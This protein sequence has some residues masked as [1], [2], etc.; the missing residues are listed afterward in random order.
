MV[1]SYCRLK[2]SLTL[3]V[4]LQMGMIYVVKVSLSMFP[5]VFRGD[6]SKRVLTL[7]VT[8]TASSDNMQCFIV[9]ETYG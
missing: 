8:S 9:W 5:A 2:H 4:R 1:K 6:A 3:A 7:C